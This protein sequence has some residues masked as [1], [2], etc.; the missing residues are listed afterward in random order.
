M[1]IHPAAAAAREALAAEIG[2]LGFR[3][4]TPAGDDGSNVHLF[5]RDEPGT[6]R[7]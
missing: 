1:E 7:D 2:R 6:D 5:A 3:D 4:V